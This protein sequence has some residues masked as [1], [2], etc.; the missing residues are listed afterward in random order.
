MESMTTP[1]ND[2][3]RRAG[4]EDVTSIPQ[5]GKTPAIGAPPQNSGEPPKLGAEREPGTRADGEAM[6]P[7][8]IDPEPDGKAER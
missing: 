6:P 3:A 1:T 4:A 7:D 8:A 2:P 5:D